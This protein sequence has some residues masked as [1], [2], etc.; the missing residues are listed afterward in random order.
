MFSLT[1][2]GN[3]P[4]ELIDNLKKMVEASAGNIAPATNPTPAATVPSTEWAERTPSSYTAP[5]PA[6]V[7][8]SNTIAQSVPVAAT[9]PTSPTP[10]Q[11]SPAAA[12]A[13]NTSPFSPIPL[14]TA[15]AYTLD[16][17]SRAGAV[18][19]QVSPGKMAEVQALLVKFKVKS[20]HELPAELYGSFATELRN[21]G[22]QI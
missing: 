20:V 19:L 17:L 8:V 18:L 9:A 5:T 1:V 15:P 12:V 11:T 3:T 14:A 7:P 22:A 21:L 13:T 4:A 10:I 6:T 16:D 2:Q